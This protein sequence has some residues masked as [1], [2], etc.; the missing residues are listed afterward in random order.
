MKRP[1]LLQFSVQLDIFR[2]I[3][4]V[5]VTMS[6]GLPELENGVILVRDRLVYS[7]RSIG[8]RKSSYGFWGSTISS[9]RGPGN[10]WQKSKHLKHFH[11]IGEPMQVFYNR[12]S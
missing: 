6:F 11:D 12:G 10:H 9:Q 1:H 3:W 4:A 8:P 5:V 7:V 2:Y